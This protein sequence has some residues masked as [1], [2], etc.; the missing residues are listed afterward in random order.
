MLWVVND[1]KAGQAESWLASSV[2]QPSDSFLATF[3]IAIF[4]Y[5]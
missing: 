3:F 1:L 5:I 4:S 2:E